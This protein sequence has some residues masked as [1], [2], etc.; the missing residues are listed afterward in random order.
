MS[1]K[2]RIAILLGAGCVAALLVRSWLYHRYKNACTSI[3]P[4]TTLADAGEILER[5]GGKKVAVIGDEHQW[6]RVR[7]SFKHQSC[8]VKVDSDEN[9]ISTRYEDSWDLL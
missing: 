9:V 2:W 3:A 5:F 1:T 4:G 7:L 6:L 8:L